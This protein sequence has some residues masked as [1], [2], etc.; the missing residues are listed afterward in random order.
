MAK[1]SAK[2]ERIPRK[3]L[4]TDKLVEALPRGSAK[5]A[6][7]SV[8]SNT[9]YAVNGFLGN[10][11]A[12]RLHEYERALTTDETVAA[13]LDFVQL[14]IVASLGEYQ[15]R[16]PDIQA[17]V[18]ENLNAMEGNYKQAIG[19]LSLSALWAG[20]GV[21]EIIW[22]VEN[23]K[24]WIERLANYHPATIHI[25][26][27][28]TGT[29][30]EHGEPIQGGFRPPGIYQTDLIRAGD[31]TKLPLS[32]TCLI[33]HRRRHGN[34]YGES[35]I[36]RV[37]KNWRYKDPGLEMWAIALDRYGTPVVYAIVPNVSTGRE[38]TD[39]GA[40]DG[41]RLET[42]AD[43][44][45][46]AISN[47]HLGTGLVLEQP[48]PENKV[49]LGTL[50]TGNNFGTSFEAFIGHL[51]R[52]IYRGLLIPQL[53]F[54]EGRGGL[55]GQAVAKI[56]FDVYKLMLQSLYAQFIEPFTEQVIGRLVRYNFNE[57]D[58]GTFPMTPFDAATAELLARSWETMVSVGALD[59]SNVSD[60]NT[61]RQ[62][63]G[64]PTIDKPII[65]SINQVMT[66]KKRELDIEEKKSTQSSNSNREQKD[67]QSMQPPIV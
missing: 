30:T 27:D 51:D 64:L 14:S 37:Y 35:I 49:S 61:M 62:T 63:V 22:T 8:L 60:L 48:D 54:N 17:F 45:I 41:K 42:L 9:V 53:I 12:I 59:P 55:G 4:K 16:N 23:G 36:R 50:T 29:L 46:N 39:S 6:G 11:D 26:V 34:Y 5:Q 7:S 66:D 2:L 38:I 1:N 18:R 19:E 43:T 57:S 33:S 65:K 28:K 56:H 58:P 10:P 20:F 15:H 13:A 31:Y 52:S 3:N 25:S 21:S 47:I 44:A 32:K 67:A 24:I 40:P